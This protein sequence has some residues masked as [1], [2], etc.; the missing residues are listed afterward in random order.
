MK[1]RFNP[2]ALA[3]LSVILVL[4][5]ASGIF[6]GHR[7]NNSSDTGSVILYVNPAIRIDYDQNGVVTK[8]S[9][10]NEDGAQI[11]EAAPSLIGLECK[12]AIEALVVEISNAGYF[13]NAD[14]KRNILLK[15]ES[16]SIVPSKDFASQIGAA[17]ENKVKELSIDSQLITIEQSDYQNSLFGDS[18]YISLE[19]AKEIALAHAGVLSENAI[20][21][22]HDFDHEKGVAVYEL[23]FYADGAEYEY[24]INAENGAV[25]K[26][27]CE[28]KSANKH[29][30]HENHSHHQ[31]QDPSP[32][33]VE[34]SLPNQD[35]TVEPAPVQPAEPNEAPSVEVAPVAPEYIGVE[36]AK[37][38]AL[39]HAGV[40]AE[41]A[42]FI[43]EKLERDDGRYEYD[44]EFIA[45]NVKYEYE[46]DAQSGEIKKHEKEQ[47]KAQIE[48]PKAEEPSASE[49]SAAERAKQIALAHA[50]VDASYVECEFDRENGRYV[51]EIEF[52]SGNY[53]FEYEINA[54][55][56]EIIKS[57]KEFD[58]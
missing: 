41:S 24:D 34:P 37:E 29:H 4:A 30:S 9:G 39:A 49:Y 56:G 48:A 58:D 18:Q 12:D 32:A 8:V 21:D 1:R 19:K 17:M 6:I 5:L 57:E 20:F 46:I 14:V 51:Y 31:S 43:K 36:K 38:I 47:K 13:D 27:K 33:P 2:K 10:A 26:H 54:Q 22:D 42:S 44:I 3:I 40:A 7:L 35:Q 50:G 52:R 53:E 16:G 15:F 23:E 45:E 55:S 11:V 28:Q 25:I